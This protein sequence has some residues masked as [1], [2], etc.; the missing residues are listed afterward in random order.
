MRFNFPEFQI[1]N[2]TSS[3]LIDEFNKYSKKL[4]QLNVEGKLY[5]LF[6][7]DEE[8]IVFYNPNIT[9]YSK[10]KLDKSI[11]IYKIRKDIFNY[12]YLSVDTSN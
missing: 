9:S 12:Y 4:L 7:N 3:F 11:E 6:E 8:I 5:Y 2:D 1:K 10:K